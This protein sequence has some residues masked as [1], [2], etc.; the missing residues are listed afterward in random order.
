MNCP[1]CQNPM[2]VLEL[3]MVEIDHCSQCGGIWLDSGELEQLFEDSKQ[4]E[5][6][7]NS[8]KTRQGVAENIHQCPICL[9]QM[10]KAAAS[11]E[12]II[13]RCSKR[14][15]LWFDKN[16]LQTILEKSF[17]GRE[18]KIMRLLSEMFSSEKDK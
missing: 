14:H 16:E 10:E 4:A 11:S 6:L 12:I 18:N 9:K 1:A 2:I 3:D 5:A 17:F 7:I 8:F 15:G 13:D